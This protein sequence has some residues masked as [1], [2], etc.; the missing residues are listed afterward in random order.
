[1]ANR[2]RHPRKEIEAAVEY[3]IHCGWQHTKATGH[4]WGMLRCP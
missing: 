2:P 4:A 1:M 3:A